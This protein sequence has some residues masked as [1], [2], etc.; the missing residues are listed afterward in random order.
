MMKLR[1]LSILIALLILSCNKKEPTLCN[2]N[3]NEK[4]TDYYPLTV[5]SYWIYN[6]Y[7]IDS[8]Q[9]EFI[10]A[11]DSSYISKDTLIN[12]KKYYIKND[13]FSAGD[14]YRGCVTDS[15]NYIIGLGGLKKLSYNNFTDTLWAETTSY[16]ISYSKMTNNGIIV[17]VPAGTF[18]TLKQDIFRYILNPNY[19]GENPY[20]DNIYYAKGVGLVK[21]HFYVNNK[22]WSER[23]LVKYHIQ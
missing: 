18:T 12:G 8:N 9:V 10:D 5:S 1:L 22:Q 15:S 3:N 16:S 17:I 21:D 11:V 20:T 4:V 6:E 14:F 19:I 2:V 13:K 23:R 7:I